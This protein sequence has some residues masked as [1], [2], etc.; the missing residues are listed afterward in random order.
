MLRIRLSA[1]ALRTSFDLSPSRR[2]LVVLNSACFQHIIDPA[3]DRRAAY[4]DD[5]LARIS[6][7]RRG[8]LL[9]SLARGILER[10]HPESEAA[11]AG[12]ALTC[13]NGRRL[14]AEWDF[15]LGGRRVEIKSSMLTFDIKTRVWRVVFSNIKLSRGCLHS[16]QPFD[17][18]YLLIYTPTGFYLV[19]HDLQTCVSKDGIRTSTR[20]HIVQIRGSV[21]EFSWEM[22][23]KTVLN[24]LMLSGAC[25]LVATV[26]PTDPI[27]STL[28]SQL[29]RQSQDLQD[30]LYESTPLS[31]MSNCERG[32]RIQQIALD[33]DKMQNPG[34]KFMDASGEPTTA[35]HRRRRSIHT[36]AVDWI[37]DSLRVEVKSAKVCFDAKRQVWGCTFRNIKNEVASDGA[38]MLH[39]DEL[40]LVMYS[41]CGLDLFKH[42]AYRSSLSL[43]G[44]GCVEGG[45]IALQ[46]RRRDAC[47]EAAVQRMK[48][49]LEAVGA[50]H[51][52]TVLWSHSHIKS[53][54][55][56]TG[57][58]LPMKVWA[59]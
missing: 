42:V 28:Y 58:N 57:L 32:I 41:P 49:K 21:G 44:S 22:A 26:S 25:E 30:N 34:S 52:F 36:A 2:W 14:N 9:E 10:L 17:D 29:S 38:R 24:K 55:K 56:I 54:R 47:V 35:N 53:Q 4:G 20:G 46:A 11:D 16:M 19:K 48:A 50:E 13:C 45:R 12:S 6:E 40:W 1:W 59:V 7:K 15:S 27:V 8:M 43:H 3:T 33:W 39:F 18:L 37:R 23:V 31:T 51:I 5:P